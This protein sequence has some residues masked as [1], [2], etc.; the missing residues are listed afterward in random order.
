MLMNRRQV[1][2]VAIILAV[3]TA[4]RA[5]LYP[6]IAIRGDLGYWMLD[7]RWITA[8]MRPFVDFIGRS[9]LFLYGYAGVIEVAGASLAS[10]RWFVA[11]L[12]LG[13]G[14]V[15]YATARSASGHR[16]GM[17]A[18]VAAT[19]TPFPIAFT[20]F[21]SSQSLGVLAVSVGLWLLVAA[22]SPRRYA[23]MGGL[24]GLAFLSRRSLVLA[25]P[26]LASWLAIA[27]VRGRPWRRVVASAV[28]TGVGFAGVL[29]AGYL[30]L[31]AGDVGTAWDLF[32]IHFIN[33]F[34]STG[35]GGVPL[36]E[37]AD[38]VAQGETA[39]SSSG[40]P[41][42][43][44]LDY[45]SQLALVATAI[46]GAVLLLPV[47]DWLRAAS[48]RYLRP[49]DRTLFHTMVAALAA[50]TAAQAA[51]GGLWYRL[52]WLAALATIVTALWHRRRLPTE[53]LLTPAVTLPVL[54]FAWIGVGYAIRPNLLA[55]YYALDAIL[56]LAVPLGIAAVH[57]W[58]TIS[59]RRRGVLAIAVAVILVVG[60]TPLA[61]LTPEVSVNADG[62]HDRVPF[63]TT[64]NVREV[65]ADVERLAGPDGVV[66]TSQPNYVALND[67]TV[68]EQNS[69]AVYLR[70]LFGDTGP[71]R[72]YYG[73]LNDALRAGT[74]DLVVQEKYNRW[75]VE[76]NATVN[77][78]LHECYGPV[79]AGPLYEAHNTTLMT[80]D[81]C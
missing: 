66:L 73:R 42:L 76:T 28:A 64:E 21:S 56:F 36:L 30:A 80:Y 18:L 68:F 50:L 22:E 40:N 10:F 6:H 51:L 77:Q 48:E 57:W 3:A 72:A 55:A 25:L 19:L 13:V 78:T 71:Q 12:W 33:L 2:H 46:A 35:S 4:V 58:P 69:R 14:V 31:A 24:V 26:A 44:L 45:R 5:V 75:L 54:L 9:P 29:G 70:H 63:F 8:G 47:W 37:M 65:N 61:P 41:L 43:S 27:G 59:S 38:A 32:I 39:T 1:A 52:V 11:S 81:G 74:I 7:S 62:R 49:L 23:I 67:A 60:G 79:E 15:A 16:A 17:V 34:V 20:F 53:E